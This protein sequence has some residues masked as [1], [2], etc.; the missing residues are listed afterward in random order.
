MTD[1]HVVAQIEAAEQQPTNVVVL[2][3]GQQVRVRPVPPFLIQNIMN[4]YPIPEPPEVAVDT[5]EG[6]QMMENPNDPDYLASVQR[7]KE[8]R[9]MAVRSAYLLKGLDIELPKD[10]SWLEDLD[11]I[12]F[13]RPQ[14]AGSRKLA[15]VETVLVQTAGDIIRLIE[16]ITQQSG[17]SEGGIAAA[18]ARFR[19]QV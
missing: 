8:H 1:E 2:S 15:Y 9:E 5:V 13:P 4:R 7:I 6:R 17:V 3:G 19:S 10:D 14:T 11:L 12:G 16:A 18:A